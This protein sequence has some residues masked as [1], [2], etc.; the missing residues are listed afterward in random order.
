VISAILFDL[1]ETLLDRTGSLVAFLADQ[2][3]RFGDRLGSASLESWRTE[4]LRLDARG[5]VHKSRVYPAILAAFGGDE[6]AAEALLADYQ[7]NCCRFA[8]PFPGMAE[9]LETLRG[10]G[11]AIGVVTN[12]ETAFQSRH[13]E[14]L[15]LSDRVDA[16][17][18]SEREGLRKPDKALFLRAAVRLGTDPARC[19]FVGDNPMADILGAHAAGMKTAWFRSGTPWPVEIAAPPGAVISR[20]PE[21]LTLVARKP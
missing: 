3:S 1:D 19:L 17:L 5:H 18:I 2:H 15:S 8:R 4:F 20:L 13:I 9:T 11:F 21:V 7:S 14:A 12:G 10:R 16:I 6:S